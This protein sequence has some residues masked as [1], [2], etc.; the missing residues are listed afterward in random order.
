MFNIF[1]IFMKYIIYFMCIIC[2]AEH[3]L[4]FSKDKDFC[5]ENVYSPGSVLSGFTE[6]C[7]GQELVKSSHCLLISSA[8]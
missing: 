8:Y 3:F 4:D 5:L 1:G 6:D 7:Q 2:L